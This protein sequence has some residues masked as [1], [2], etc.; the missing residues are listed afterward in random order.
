MGTPKFDVSS[1]H[2]H[3]E[4]VKNLFSP[5]LRQHIKALLYTRPTFNPFFKYRRDK[6][7]SDMEESGQIGD[8]PI[9]IVSFNRLSYLK[10]LI[11][12]LE[13]LGKHNI[14]II[15]NASTY[16]PLLE[17]YQTLHYPVIYTN[18]NYGHRVFWEC[19]LLEEYRHNFYILTDPD[20]IPIESCPL[21]F[22]EKFF[23][24]LKRYPYINKVG[25]S[26]KIDDLPEGRA[27]QINEERMWMIPEKH[28]DGFCASIDT[29]FALYVPDSIAR[30][31]LFS[32]AIRTNAPYQARHLPWYK[33]TED[34][35]DEDMY[36]SE[37]RLHWISTFDPVK[38]VRHV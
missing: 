32:D 36:Y 34:L 10:E 33:Q 1:N 25:F 3:M 19:P 8:I 24:I 21:D 37:H 23:E 26:L 14:F 15:D 6:V 22:I 29:T 35:T 16:P 7:F 17:Y 18:S 5:Y 13:Q 28:G 2:P 12:R 9:F 20:V 11:S 31:R 27:N 38:A 4:K 30:S